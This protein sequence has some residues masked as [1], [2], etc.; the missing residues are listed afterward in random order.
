LWN[1]EQ[2]AERKDKRKEITDHLV[3]KNTTLSMR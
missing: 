2:R 3:I 1:R